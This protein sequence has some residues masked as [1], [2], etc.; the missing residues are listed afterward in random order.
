M[1]VGTI[2]TQTPFGSVSRR[3]TDTTT[4]TPDL[5]DPCDKVDVGLG[6]PED[7]YHCD[8]E[9]AGGHLPCDGRQVPADIWRDIGGTGTP[10]LYG[11][12]PNPDCNG[13]GIPDACDIQYGISQDNNGNGIPDECDVGPNAGS[14]PATRGGGTPHGPPF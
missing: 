13:N 11:G 12:Y 1:A 3:L 14:A 2:A 6:T 10:P 4:R 7:Q 5:L 8:R 9:R